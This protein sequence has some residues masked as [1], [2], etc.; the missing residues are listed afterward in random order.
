M[1]CVD[2]VM[3]SLPGEGAVPAVALAA[4]LVAAG[5]SG[6][7][8]GGPDTASVTETLS[9]VP[10]PA[11]ASPDGMAGTG[12]STGELL[13]PGLTRDGVV[14]PFA[15][16]GAHRRSLSN[17]SY[18]AVAT[19]TIIGPDWPHRTVER[20]VA[21]AAGGVPYHLVETSDP[22]PTYPVTSVARR[23]EIWSGGRLAL[24]R[25]GVENVSYRRG[26][27]GSVAGP[28]V[29]LTGHDRLVGYYGSVDRWSVGEHPVPNGTRYVLESRGSLH[30]GILNVPLFL[31][32]PRDV[33]LRVVTT[34][35]G[36]VV[37][38]HLRYVAT[39]D[40]RRVTVDRSLRFEDVGTT[41]VAEPA[42]VEE[43]RAATANSA[44]AERGSKEPLPGSQ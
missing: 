19:T 3:G 5:C 9:P 2:T 18:T 31:T 41:T 29:D 12:G 15:L 43:A 17:R 6:F 33:H 16:A 26:T 1:R 7:S 36:R 44:A 35:D 34:E 24:F 37:A 40:G 27:T 22:D 8:G 20:R 21:V 14:D 39:F 32:D 28:L 10:V 11:T 38:T 30:P 23:I 42:W 13:A 25:V 4:L